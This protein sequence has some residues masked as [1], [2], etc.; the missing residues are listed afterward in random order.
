MG[1]AYES[2]TVDL[3]GQVAQVTLVGPGGS[4]KTRLAL[5]AARRSAPEG[6]TPALVELA[7]VGDPALVATEIATALGV[8]L[9]AGD[10]LGLLVPALQGRPTLLL[11]DNCEHVVD[12]VAAFIEDVLRVAPAIRILATSREPLRVEAEWLSRLAPL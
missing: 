6:L 7:G 4:G 9:T 3:H 8:T 11:L 5:E 12:A 2:V 1:D 10:A